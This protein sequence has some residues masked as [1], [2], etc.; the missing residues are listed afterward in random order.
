MSYNRLGS[1]FLDAQAGL[2]MSFR[3]L[4]YRQILNFTHMVLMAEIHC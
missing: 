2:A 4:G 1:D 3:S